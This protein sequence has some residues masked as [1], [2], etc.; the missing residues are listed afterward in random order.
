MKIKI[1]IK[2]LYFSKPDRFGFDKKYPYSVLE[3]Y[4]DVVKFCEVDDCKRIKLTGDISAYV[5]MYI[6]TIRG[7]VITWNMATKKELIK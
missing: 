1:L 5:E 4:N 7:E 2:A 6:E 3:V